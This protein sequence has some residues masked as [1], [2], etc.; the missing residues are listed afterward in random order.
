MNRKLT[1]HGRLHLHVNGPEQSKADLPWKETTAQQSAKAE[2]CR[3]LLS[4]MFSKS[5]KVYR[6]TFHCIHI[7]TCSD[8]LIAGRK[9][10]QSDASLETIGLPE[11]VDI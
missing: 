10:E 11:E 4:K 3:L 6:S 9:S 1:S 8:S 2:F 5:K 7:L